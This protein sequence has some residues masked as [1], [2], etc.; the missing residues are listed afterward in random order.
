MTGLKCLR[1]FCRALI[2]WVLVLGSTSAALAEAIPPGAIDESFPLRAADTSSPRDTLT[3]F[4]RDFRN[5][6]EAW[7]SGKSRDVIDRALARARDTIDFS[8]I[9]A[10]GYDAATLIDMALLSEV[11]D[12][13]ALPPLEEIPGDADLAAGKDD[14]LTRW[15]VPNTRLEIERMTNGPRAGEYLFSKETVAAL[16]TYY[17]LAK[18]VP[19]RPNALVGIYEDVLSSPG[20]WVPE[21]FRDTLPAW[22]KFVAAGHAIWQ[23]IALA[24]LVAVGLPL[25]SLIVLAGI[26]WDSKRLAASPWLR[27]A[28]PVALILVVALAELFENLA[29]KVVGLLELPM[30]IISLMVLAVQA[31]GL[32]WFVFLLSNRLADAIGGLR[33]GADGNPHLDAAMTRM[34]FR[35]ISLVIMI[36]L[37]AA[38]ASRI[39]IP[40]APLVAGLGAGGLAIALAV[41]PTLE[42]I[43]GGLT[44]FADRPVR[45]G[46]FCRYGDDIGTVEQ[47][48]LRSTRI[49]TLE[50][51]LV[52]VPNSEF[53]QMHLDNFTARSTRLL[54]TVLH[55]RHGTTPEQMRLL[56]TQ[57]RDLLSANPLV[58]PDSSYV[59]F[60]GYGAHS[61]D[62]EVFAYLRCEDEHAF[63]AAREEVLLS[64]E[65]IVQHVDAGFAGSGGATSISW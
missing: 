30:E 12:R 27:F 29:E 31:V 43:I 48:G 49:R 38:A 60:V 4:L 23:W 3:T 56:L 5:S 16:R 8:E 61:K 25:V 47:I 55:I 35:L 36:L 10:L 59:R 64:I 22:A 45:V 42:N 51:S 13:V 26:N 50:Q 63:L 21:R 14:E 41:R 24:M 46:D 9:P 6:A 53:S 32:A 11:L 34:V 7:R 39:G 54:Q 19:Y 1:L 65:E 33:A 28:T 20:D 17:D 37:V 2:L 57:I 18:D 40:I 52:T 15:V 58:V 62:I 44:L